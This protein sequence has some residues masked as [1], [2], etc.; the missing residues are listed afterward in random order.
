MSRIEEFPQ[1]NKMLDIG[2]F[3]RFFKIYIKFVNIYIFYNLKC[4]IFW[5]AVKKVK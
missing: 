1:K 4:K 2:Y 5:P 3:I